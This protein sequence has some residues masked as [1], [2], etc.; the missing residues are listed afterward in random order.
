M[1]LASWQLPFLA[2]LSLR[3]KYLPAIC[4]CCL[5]HIVSIVVVSSDL[6]VGIMAGFF[7][8]GTCNQLALNVP[9]CTAPAEQ[10]WQANLARNLMP[11]A[12]HI[13]LLNLNPPANPAIY[14]IELTLEGD[15]E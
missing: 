8:C 6:L 9:L 5:N 11:R 15:S 2:K 14:W 12:V 4:C 3:P 13:C 1:R 7:E 10:M